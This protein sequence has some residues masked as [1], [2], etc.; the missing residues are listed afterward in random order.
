[1]K[2]TLMQQSLIKVLA[3]IN[4][5]EESKILIAL[6]LTKDDQICEFFYWLKDNVTEYNM[7]SMEE[8]ICGKAVEFSKS[9]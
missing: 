7:L 2:K 6:T 8:E 4:M 3:S 1:M 9:K 5:S